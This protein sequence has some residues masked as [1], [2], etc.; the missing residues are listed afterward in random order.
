M[1]ARMIQPGW[2][3]AAVSAIATVAMVGLLLTHWRRLRE[4]TL[5]PALCWAVVAT[6]AVGGGQVAVHLLSPAASNADLATW[7]LAAA[8]LT[9][10]PLLAVLGAMRPQHYYWN[11]IVFSAWAIL[12]LPAAETYFI[13]RGQPL[14]ISA[15][16]AWFLWIMILLGPVNFAATRFGLSAICLALGQIVLLSSYLPLIQRPITS[17]PELAGLV[18]MLFALGLASF[19]ARKQRTTTNPYDRVW[20]DFRDTFG[21]LW[22]LRFAER[23][24]AAAAQYGWDFTLTWSGFRSTATAAPLNQISPEIEPAFRATLVGL[25]RRFVSADWIAARM[26]AESELR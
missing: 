25:L 9:F 4:T 18:I 8:A 15:A 23:V 17:R 14:E 11:F 13:N 20:L 2:P 1:I 26:G 24:N 21:M 5:L 19:A 6:L 16:R 10:C 22:G 7:Q 12:A 3:T